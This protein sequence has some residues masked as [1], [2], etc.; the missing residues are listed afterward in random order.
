MRYFFEPVEEEIQHYPCGI[1]SLNVTDDHKAIQCDFCNYWS[2]IECEGIDML[3]YENLMKSSESEIHC[4]PICNE[5]MLNNP[6]NLSDIETHMIENLDLNAITTPDASLVNFTQEGN[7]IYHCGICTKKVGL[8][9]KAVFCDLCE[10]WNHIKCDGIDDKTYNDLK[11]SNDNEKYYCKACKESIFP[12][13]NLSDDEYFTSI[14]KNID[15]NE[16]LNL[17]LFPTPSLKT[18]FT[19]FSNQNEDG[20]SINCDY[21]DV[22]APIPSANNS[23]HSMF[24]LNLASL[25]L[26]KDELVTS[27]SL[28]D[29][30]F[31][32]IAVS[33]TK[34]KLGT[35]P[36]YDLSLAGYRHHQ[37]P[38]ESNKGGVIIYAKENVIT[39]RRYDLERKMYKARELESVF[40]EIINEG[41]RNEIFGCIYRHPSMDID[42]FNKNFFKDF[43]EKLS[44]ENKITYLSGDFNID[45]LKADTDEKISEFYNSLTSNLFVPHITLE[46]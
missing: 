22:S 11:K 4:C 37:T 20:C 10:Q 33:E 25:G 43:I 3:T 21:Y 8:R 38:S 9:N 6:H 7:Q 13:H 26:H 32:M 29:F 15:V 28:L 46:L 42:D 2:H 31:D 18:L 35:E 27:L 19:D 5:E 41:K 39:R 14:I 16:D 30:E 44:S 17:R 40:L 24:H 23:K 34:I 12:F 36:I 1:C 45:L